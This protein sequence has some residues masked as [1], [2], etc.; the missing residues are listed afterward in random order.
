VR[1]AAI[2]L[3]L[4]AAC[5]EPPRP[6]STPSAPSPG[7]L[8]Q[9]E[10]ALKVEQPASRE[11]GTAVALLVDT[12]G[13]MG[14]TVRNASG[15]ASPKIE[16][17]RASAL[18]VVA[19]A[20]KY[21]KERPDKKILLA[22]YEFSS[23]GGVPNC[24]QVVPLGPPSEAGARPQVEQMR[25]SGNTPIGDAMIAA[26]RDLDATGLSSLHLLVVTDGENTQ[27]Y[28]PGD[29]AAA[30]ARH[31]EEQ[32]TSLYFVAFDVASSKFEAVKR[33]GGLLVG[34]ADARELQETLDTILTGKILIEK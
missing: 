18:K 17:A 2:G 12:S 20:E 29:V 3:F 15:G 10:T 21:A 34:A 13:S 6:P 30:L 4:L 8:Q 31:K 23:R 19:T 14:E 27:G 24:R 7:I 26:K 22:V 32:T 1:R 9:I 16:I 5:E 25:A 33:E 11:V 28:D